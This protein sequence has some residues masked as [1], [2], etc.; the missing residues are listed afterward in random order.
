M[1]L[2]ANVF[3][4]RRGLFGTAVMLPYEWI[5]SVVLSNSGDGFQYK[6][7]DYG[8]ADQIKYNINKIKFKK[9]NIYKKKTK[10][11]W[12]AFEIFSIFSFIW[13]K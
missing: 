8:G 9:K 11:E 13:I 10:I 4:E 3:Y 2:W 1:T 12:N 7:T 6:F 5:Q